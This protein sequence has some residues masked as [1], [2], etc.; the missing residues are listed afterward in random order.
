[1]DVERDNMLCGIKDTD[2]LMEFMCIY[3]NLIETTCF[4]VQF[5]QVHMFCDDKNLKLAPEVTSYGV[6][7]L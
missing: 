7:K 1:M 3:L 2:N 5:S 4:N 6:Y